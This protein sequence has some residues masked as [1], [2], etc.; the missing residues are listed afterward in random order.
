MLMG[1]YAD[2]SERS[3][4]HCLRSS[5]KAAPMK[6]ITVLTDNGSQFIDRLSAHSKTP[7][8]QH[9]FDQQCTAFGIECRLSPTPSAD[10]RHGRALQWLRCRSDRTDP[11]ASAIELEST[12]KNYA[13]IYNQDVLQRTLEHFSPIQAMKKWQWD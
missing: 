4:T 6:I 2:Q 13:A 10:Q 9:V 5:H 12:L 3:S 7:I 11:L 1:I 8:G